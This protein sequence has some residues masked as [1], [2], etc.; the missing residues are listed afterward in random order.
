M[1]D[2]IVPSAWVKCLPP[3]IA[4]APLA[5]VAEERTKGVVIYPPPGQIFRALELVAPEEVRAVILGQD[6]YHEP[7]QAMGLAFAVPSECKKLPPS[8]KNILKEYAADLGRPLP[9]QPDLTKWARQGVLLLNTILSVREHAAFSHR[10]IGWEAVTDAIL[11]SVSALPR[12]VVFVLW[13]APAQAKRGLID[14]TRHAVIA[15]PH[16]SPLSAYRGFFG[17]RPFTAVNRLLEEAG[18]TPIDWSL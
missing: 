2:D 3:D 11:S 5:A 18:R 7:G 16:P 15:S 17:S 14:E 9:A 8:L 13:G 4:E 10:D 1:P 6:P 12:R